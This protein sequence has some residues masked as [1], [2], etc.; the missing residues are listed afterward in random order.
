MRFPFKSQDS[1]TH[2]STTPCARDA[3]R[4]RQRQ[5]Q[6]S[7]APT[8][9]SSFSRTVPAQIR[10]LF[11]FWHLAKGV[12][13]FV[14]NLLKGF[15]YQVLAGFLHLV[16]RHHV[17]LTK[18]S[19]KPSFCPFWTDTPQLA[20]G[21]LIDLHLSINHPPGVYGSQGRAADGAQHA[22]AA[23][24]QRAGAAAPGMAGALK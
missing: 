20:A 4:F 11:A 9:G 6:Y 10:R 18:G 21:T 23:H 15:L 1:S 24:C 5:H 16:G 13:L 19:R 7:P 2:G 22:L 12:D 17:L 14:C 3:S 8:P